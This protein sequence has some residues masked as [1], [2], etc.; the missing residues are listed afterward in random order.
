MAMKSIRMFRL[1]NMRDNLEQVRREAYAEIERMLNDMRP[2]IA[3]TLR[4]MEVVHENPV[5]F[6][7]VRK[8]LLD[9]ILPKEMVEE[10]SMVKLEESYEHYIGGF[11]VSDRL[12]LSSNGSL[13]LVGDKSRFDDTIPI[14]KIVGTSKVEPSELSSFRDKLFR[15][16]VFMEAYEKELDDVLDKLEEYFKSREAEEEPER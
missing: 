11:L 16:D 2:R 3:D 14:E 7:M 6:D 13:C 5:L 4:L 9:S 8:G 1:E 10:F 15:L 12:A